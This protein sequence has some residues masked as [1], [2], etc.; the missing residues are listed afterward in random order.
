MSKRNT[1]AQEMTS[2]IRA[3]SILI[4][5]ESN[6]IQMR[7]R[8]VSALCSPVVLGADWDQTLHRWAIG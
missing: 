2:T 3:E 1:K 7:L 5:G 8:R 4:T 6:W